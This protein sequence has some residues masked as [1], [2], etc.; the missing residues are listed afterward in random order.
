MKKLSIIIPVYNEMRT[1]DELL[2]R[3]EAVKLP[4]GFGKE[5]ILVDDCSTDGT[6]QKIEAFGKKYITVFHGVN[7]GKGASVTDGLKRSSGDIVVIQDAD[8]EYDPED[9]NELLKPILTGKADVV[10]GSRLLTSR[11]HRV[12][13]F[14]HSLGNSLLTFVSNLFTNIN[15]TDMETCY[16]MFTREVVDAIK[17]RLTAN[18]FGIEPEITARVKKFRIYEVGISYAGRTYGEG[19]K[20]NWKDGIAAFWYIIK[21]NIFR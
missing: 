17:D 15:L 3:V 4:D 5:I 6:K 20:I 14:W 21:F 13:Y 11:P 10:Y 12:M 1:L 8:L 9:Y 7:R 16:K 19:K 2:R 18:R